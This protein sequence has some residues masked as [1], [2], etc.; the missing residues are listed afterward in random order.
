MKKNLLVSPSPHIRTDETVESIMWDVVIALIPAML[1]SIYFFR[2]QAI[3]VLLV[4]VISAVVVE[5]LCQIVMQREIQ[6]FDGSA[7]VT[8]LLFAFVVPPG[9]SWWV[10]MI[11]S[12]ISILLGKM[13][14]GGL[15]HNIF[16]PALVG[17]AFVTASW[18][19]AITTFTNLDG[20]AGPT[21]LGIVKNYDLSNGFDV[22]AGYPFMH[23]LFTSGTIY[24]DMF[25]GNIP[26]S[27]GETSVLAL[28]I[29][30]AYLFYKKHI[31]WH[32]PVSYVGTV[33]IL[34]LITG[35]DP[36]LHILS[37]GLILGALFMATDMVTTPY[38]K[39]GKF[40]F[41]VGAGVLVVL[42]RLRGGYPEG[43][44]YSIL[45]MNGFTPLINK[46]T[47][48]RVFGEVKNNG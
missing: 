10:T 24:V 23:E 22:I 32:I 14:F 44:C 15:G 33:F 43:V 36:F 4:S 30:G 41:G 13:V 29:G 5:V 16:N 48:P 18:P 37:G 12:G 20:T 25:I 17:R 38:T 11:G 2:M 6:I 31:T 26:G 1:I 27:L 19:V 42:I 40:I 3:S 28:L 46:Y 39:V 21:V 7:V 47:R 34:M 45:I 35:N 8:G 9:M